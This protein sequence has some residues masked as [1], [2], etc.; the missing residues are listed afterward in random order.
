MKTF[1]FGKF[2]NGSFLESLERKLSKNENAL[3]GEETGS[4]DKPEREGG[5]GAEGVAW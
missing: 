3:L 1:Q 4:G 2:E 5:R